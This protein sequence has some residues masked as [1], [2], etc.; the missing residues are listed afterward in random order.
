MKEVELVWVELDEEMVGVISERELSVR[1][2]S[3]KMMVFDLEIGCYRKKLEI[4]DE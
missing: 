1:S 4:E 2:K 3:C